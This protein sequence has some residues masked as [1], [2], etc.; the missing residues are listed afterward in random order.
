M[1]KSKVEIINTEMIGMK[2]FEYRTNLVLMLIDG[3]GAGVILTVAWLR[4]FK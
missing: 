4:G 1:A 3:F 2:L